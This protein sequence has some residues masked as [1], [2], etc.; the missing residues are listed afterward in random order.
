MVTCLL[1]GNLINRWIKPFILSSYA[2]V[3]PAIRKHK[4][5]QLNPLLHLPSVSRLDAEGYA[6]RELKGVPL[7]GWRVH[8][9]WW[10]VEVTVHGAHR[11]GKV[12][13]GGKGE[14][15]CLRG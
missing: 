11:E 12:P 13:V 5:G 1:K 10:I 15:V 6:H 2:N 3:S 8:R 9:R 14:G 7:G 4:T